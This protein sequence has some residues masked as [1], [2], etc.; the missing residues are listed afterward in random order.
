MIVNLDIPNTFQWSFS[1]R[2]T[3][4]ALRLL[5]MCFSLR[6]WFLYF[7]HSYNL[8]LAKYQWIVHFKY[9][10]SRNLSP[11]SSNSNSRRNLDITKTTK[12]KNKSKTKSKNKNKHKQHRS[13]QQAERRIKST[14]QAQNHLIKTNFFVKY[15]H[16]LG[17]PSL[18]LGLTLI[19]F[20]LVTISI[21]L[22]AYV[23]EGLKNTGVS[24]VIAMVVYTIMGIILASI[25]RKFSSNVADS[26]YITNELVFSV[27]MVC[28]VIFFGCIYLL[29]VKYVKLDSDW[30]R[31]DEDGIYTQWSPY[32]TWFPYFL[33]IVFLLCAFYAMILDV[34]KNNSKY[35][36]K[37]SSRSSGGTGN[38]S[39]SG[40]SN[41]SINSTLRRDVRWCDIVNNYDGYKEFM[42]FLCKELSVENMLFITE[43]TQFIHKIELRKQRIGLLNNN[44]TNVES[45]ETDIN[46]STTPSY[47]HNRNNSR[48]ISKKTKLTLTLSNIIS[49]HHSHAHDH[50]SRSPS[51]NSNNNKNNT[52]KHNNNSTNNNNNNDRINDSMKRGK[53]GSRVFSADGSIAVSTEHH[54]D[55]VPSITH[56]T[57][58]ASTDSNISI[59]I[60][61]SERGLEMEEINEIKSLKTLSTL[62]VND[63]FSKET[64]S[65]T[66]TATSGDNETTFRGG[67]LN[68]KSIGINNID[69]SIP[70]PSGNTTMRSNTSNSNSTSGDH[71]NY[72]EEE[73]AEREDTDE[74]ESSYNYCHSDVSIKGLTLPKKILS[75]QAS[76]IQESIEK[77]KNTQEIENLMFDH[78]YHKYIQAGVAPF[79]INISYLT[80]KTIETKMEIKKLGTSYNKRHNKY[81]TTVNSS[82]D[83]EED[84]NGLKDGLLAIINENE[85]ILLAFYKAAQEI[86]ILINDS[87]RRFKTTDVYEN[88]INKNSI[89]LRTQK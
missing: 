11:F 53:R 32:L 9:N 61:S 56:L 8:A 24:F 72:R 52:N 18:M 19:G 70:M 17:K 87:F 3:F 44:S 84:S 55:A 65:T 37:S 62:S 78:L 48:H 57:N 88:I 31:S 41:T 77:A 40:G 83:T 22:S 13:R 58:Q 23:I 5:G 46:K 15:K 85:E 28:I 10:S 34:I 7:D 42:A 64:A 89:L 36:S 80:R 74:R 51:D 25:W 27:K 69:I 29:I 66:T 14:T 71:Y 81:K 30:K 75:L 76:L 1:F 26:L 2:L 45:P 21:L 47:D 50:G 12:N 67:G 20:V 54:F 73:M 39:V 82:S 35:E 59:N 49:I 16:S 63:T 43:Y 86:S 79:E 68:S 4:G 6:A 33:V 60:N 38:R